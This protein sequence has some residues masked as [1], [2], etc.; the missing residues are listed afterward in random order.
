MLT[1]QLGIYRSMI[2]SL[3]YFAVASR[4]DIAHSV[5]RLSQFADKPTRSSKRALQRV[6][7]YLM[8]VPDLKIEVTRRDGADTFKFYSDSDHGGDQPH[9]TKSQTGSMI[10]LNDAPVHWTS[11]KQTDH[12]AYSSAMAEIFALSETVRASRLYAWR[13]EEMGLV[14]TYPLRVQVDN[15]ASI[16]F[17]HNTCLQSRLRGCID[18]RAA[19]VTELRE[20]GAIITEKVATEDNFADLLTKCFPS[21]KFKKL[22]R[23]I[24]GRSQETER[25]QAFIA[26][27]VERYDD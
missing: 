25:V 26:H 5:S 6:L 12:T 16:S 2:G 1:R 4:Y 23:K 24:Q 14:I 8:V 17:Q 20:K 27:I 7:Q 3:N 15:K 19:W 21:Y 11:K 18:M 9:T 10:L 13:A 22:L